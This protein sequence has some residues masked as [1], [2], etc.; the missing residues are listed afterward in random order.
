M[1]KEQEIIFNSERVNHSHLPP[2]YLP[3]ATEWLK[4]FKRQI[5]VGNGSHK[6]LIKTET[7]KF[8]QR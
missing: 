6:C 2:T 5:S 1:L 8:E 3:E 4:M 7:V